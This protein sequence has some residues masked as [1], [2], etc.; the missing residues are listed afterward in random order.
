MLQR[1]GEVIAKFWVVKL[2]G[3]KDIL[4]EDRQIIIFRGD[5]V[6]VN[7]CIDILGK[8]HQK[9]CLAVPGRGADK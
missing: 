8:I 7:H 6:P 3:L 2:E 9:G 4:V 1:E 5:A